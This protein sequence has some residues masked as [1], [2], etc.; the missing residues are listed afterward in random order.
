M[1]FY[2]INTDRNARE[3]S[4]CD[5][6]FKHGM[7]FAG[8]HEEHRGDHAALFSK[9]RPKD[10]LFMYNSKKKRRKDKEGGYVGVGIVC[11]KWDKQVYK[12]KDRLLYKTEPYEY[13]IKVNWTQDWRKSPKKGGEHALPMPRGGTHQVIKGSKCPWAYVYASGE[14]IPTME[15]YDRS[16]EEAVASSLASRDEDRRKRIESSNPK[17]RVI[18]VLTPV[19]QRNPDV[20]VEVLKRAN[21]ICDIC[22]NVA[23]FARKSDGSPY[24]EVHHIDML[25][26]GG[27]DTVENSQAL[28]PNCHR[29]AHFGQ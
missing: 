7:A 12:G 29:K 10:I 3:D 4:T 20:V 22:R 5:L 25:S 17:P 6:W 19:F 27:S 1:A 8:D 11:E 13:R 14:M 26:S 28:C 23:P 16:F 2:L 9:L 15:E 24:L 21:G 18:Y